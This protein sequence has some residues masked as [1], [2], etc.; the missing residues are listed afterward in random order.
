MVVALIVFVAALIQGVMGFGGALVAMPLL[1]AVLGIQ[2]ASPTFALVA[3]VATLFNAIRWRAHATP[4]DLVRLVVPALVGIPLGV[5][6]LAQVN[7]AVITRT[8]GAILIFYAAYSLL[9]LAVPLLKHNA[10]AYSAGFTSGVLTG[11]YNTGGPPVIVFANAR[12]WSPERFRA[13]LQTYFLISSVTV[14]VSHWLAGHYT[15]LIWQT[16]LWAMPALIA[17]QLVGIRLCRYVKPEIFRRLVLL[18]LLVLGAQ[19][20]FF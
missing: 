13:N 9:G 20:L 14:V 11:A 8:L 16:A 19:L 10:W 2:T 1:V 7:E 5:W 4:S 18:F 6:L 17:G 15:P 3:A 12:R